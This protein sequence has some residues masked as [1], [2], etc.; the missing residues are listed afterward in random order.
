MSKL[1]STALVLFAVAILMLS[2]GCQMP[3]G[4]SGGY[5]GSDGHSGHSH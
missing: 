2:A 5:S 1:I 3:G 4:G